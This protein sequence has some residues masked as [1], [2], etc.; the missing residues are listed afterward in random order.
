MKKTIIMIFAALVTVMTGCSST[1][2]SEAGSSEAPASDTTVSTSTT[3]AT[4]TEEE[5][6]TAMVERSLTSI[7]NPSRIKAKIEQAKSGEK[8]VVAYIGGSITE[9]YAGGP[10]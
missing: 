3:S 6:H 8:T 2:E 9:G 1:Q 4:M 5:Y 7:G 10:D